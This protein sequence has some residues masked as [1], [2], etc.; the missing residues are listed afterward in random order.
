V[1]DLAPA[2]ARGIYLSLNAQC[3]SLG[4]LI[5]PVI[6]G[7]AIDQTPAIAQQLWIVAAL[8]TLVGIGILTYLKRCLTNVSLI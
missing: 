3:W 1:S 2:Q 4:Y 5:G 7:W 6:G 8:S